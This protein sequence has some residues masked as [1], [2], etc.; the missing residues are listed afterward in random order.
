M[1]NKIFFLL[2][3]HSEKLFVQSNRVGSIKLFV[4]WKKNYNFFK[5]LQK[6]RS[7]SI[8]GARSLAINSLA[9]YSLAI[10][11]ILLSASLAIPS[12]AINTLAICFTCARHTCSSLTCYQVNLLLG[13][14]CYQHVCSQVKQLM[15]SKSSYYLSYIKIVLL[16][17]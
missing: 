10:S 13:L 6:I 14:T 9:F 2:N 16:S 12:F 3:D 1:F 4:Q 7:S 11:F 15:L 8:E 5:T 17:K